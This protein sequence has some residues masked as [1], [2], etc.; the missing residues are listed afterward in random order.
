MRA[1]KFSDAQKAFIH[2]Q[3]AAG[4]PGGGYQRASLSTSHGP[5][6]RPTMPSSKHSMVA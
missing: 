2:K 4:M 6:N 3:G 5:G 1:S